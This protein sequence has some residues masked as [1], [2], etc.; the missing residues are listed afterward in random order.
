MLK[1]FL[2]LGLFDHLEKLQVEVYFVLQLEAIDK[3]V[4]T[5]N[6]GQSNPS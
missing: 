4:L 6:I 2:L 5:L 1:K 3:E